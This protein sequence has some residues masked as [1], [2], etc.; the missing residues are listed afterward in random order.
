MLYEGLT[1]LFFDKEEGIAF[2]DYPTFIAPEV[3]KS[4]HLPPP[5]ESK[6]DLWSLGILILFCLKGEVTWELW[7][8]SCR[9]SRSGD[10]LFRS[11]IPLLSV[12][13]F[14]STAAT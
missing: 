5:E 12:T 1:K 11:I 13:R 4:N 2:S 8:R 3:L 10:T 7:A 14:P 9:G 6:I